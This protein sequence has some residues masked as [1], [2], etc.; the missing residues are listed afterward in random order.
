MCVRIIRASSNK[1]PH[2]DCIPVTAKSGIV[3]PRLCTLPLAMEVMQLKYMYQVG[4]GFWVKKSDHFKKCQSLNISRLN[5]Y[6]SM[7]QL[8]ICSQYWFHDLVFSYVTS[9]GQSEFPEL[10]ANLFRERK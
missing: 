1:N 2:I 6:T 10:V 7:C 5:V 4:I 9:R 3:R 8:I